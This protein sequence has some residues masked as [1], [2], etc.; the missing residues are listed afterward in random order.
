MVLVGLGDKDP[1]AREV[2]AAIAGA[3]K[4]LKG[5]VL[6][7]AECFCF[8]ADTMSSRA[9]YTAT[10]L[11]CLQGGSVG[12]TRAEGVDPQAIGPHCTVQRMRSVSSCVWC[13]LSWRACFLAF[14]FGP[15]RGSDAHRAKFAAL[16]PWSCRRRTSDFKGQRHRRKRRPVARRDEGL[17]WE[18]LVDLNAGFGHPAPIVRLQR[19]RTPWSCLAMSPQKTLTRPVMQC[20]ESHGPMPNVKFK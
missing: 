10:S 5:W 13:R 9:G 2:G 6:S 12:L 18:K 8:G 20:T 3:V 19:A 14:T 4:G 7:A 11:P 16:A 1:N 17:I 15:W